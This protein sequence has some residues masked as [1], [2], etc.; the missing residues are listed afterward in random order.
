[1]VPTV[2]GSEGKSGNFKSTR[3]KKDIE[4]LER[5][6]RR[7][8]KVVKGFKKMKYKERL[9]HLGIYSLEKRRLRGDLIEVYKIRYGKER[10]DKATFFQLA[11]D[12]HGL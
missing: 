11:I 10:V 2:R 6:Q 8:T 4:C 5:I 3:L 12:G 7:A 9:K 1:M